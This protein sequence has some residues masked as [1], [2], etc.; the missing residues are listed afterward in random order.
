MILTKQVSVTISNNG[1]YYRELGYGVC[2]FREIIL[3]DVEDLPINCN[4]VVVCSCDECDEKFERSLQPLRRSDKHLCKDC[5]YN[6][7][8]SKISLAMLGVPRLNSRGENHPRYRKKE[9]YEEEYR[10]LVQHLSNSNYAE[11]KEMIDPEN[12]GRQFVTKENATHLDHIIS[13]QYGIDNDIDYRVISSP[14]NLRMMSAI[15]NIKKNKSSDMTIE[16]LY[17]KIEEIGFDVDRDT[18]ISLEDMARMTPDEKKRRRS[19]RCAIGGKLGA[20]M[21]RQN[22]SGIFGLTHEQRSENSKILSERKRADGYYESETWL[23]QC[24]NGGKISGKLSSGCRWYNDGIK[25]YKYTVRMMEEVPF[26]DFLQQRP[27]YIEG[28]LV[29]KDGIAYK[30]YNDGV[31]NYT[32]SNKEQ[33]ELD[34]CLFMNKHPKFFKGRIKHKNR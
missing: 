25:N 6:A 4:K 12:L 16:E 13:I 9:S 32:Y 11:F 17:S 20:S 28:K 22:K 15:D 5:S 14:A 26:R 29:N 34:F 7:R 23:K 19:A 1:K 27:E 21:G 31:I 8:K 33:S 2:K 24:S 18:K 10:K 3:V 30:W